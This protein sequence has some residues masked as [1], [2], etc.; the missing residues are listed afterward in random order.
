M[1]L[2]QHTDNPNASQ[3][4]M[5][6]VNVGLVSDGGKPNNLLTL[7]PMLLLEVGRRR[8]EKWKRNVNEE[9]DELQHICMFFGQ[10]QCG[11]SDTIGHTKKLRTPNEW[12]AV[13][14]FQY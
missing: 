4:I 6:D 1:C 9:E 14:L 13:W 2:S 11:H 7:R 8:E 12:T 3:R 5:A 10:Q